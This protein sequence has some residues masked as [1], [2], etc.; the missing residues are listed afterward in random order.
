MHVRLETINSTTFQSSKDENRN[1]PKTKANLL[2]RATL[3]NAVRCF[4]H[5]S[6]DGASTAMHVAASLRLTTL[7][8]T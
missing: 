5:A 4:K 8:S 3:A 6:G 7:A 1:L 2:T